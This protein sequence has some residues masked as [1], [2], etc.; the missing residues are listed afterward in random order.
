VRKPAKPAVKPMPKRAGLTTNGLYEQLKEMAVLYKL[1]PGE[2]VNELELSQAFNTS[3]TPVREALNRLAS[4]KFLTFVPNRGFYGRALDR[5][6]IYNLYELRKCIESAA[7]T[8]A[9]GRAKDADILAIRTFWDDVVKRSARIPTQKL[10]ALDEEFHVRVV[11]LSGNA[12]MVRALQDVNGRIH[13]VRWVDL[14]ERKS[15]VYNEHQALVEA[16]IARDVA[17]CYAILEAHIAR[18]MEEIVRVI[19]AGVVRL[20]A[21]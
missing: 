7:V 20:Y 2:R 3:R 18:R 16:L 10:V 21:P 13:F 5:Q 8:L 15:A 12:E 17:K 1:R 6:D 4:E 9:I 14:E 11:A 19:Q